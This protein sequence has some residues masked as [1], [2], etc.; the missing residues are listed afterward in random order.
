MRTN[1]APRPPKVRSRGMRL[2]SRLRPGART[3][4]TVVT[5][6]VELRR[7]PPTPAWKDP[8]ERRRRPA[9]AGRGEGEGRA[10]GATRGCRGAGRLHPERPRYVSPAATSRA[11]WSSV[12]L[13]CVAQFMV[14]LDV[15]V[16]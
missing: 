11:R 2:R 6:I 15:S 16:V 9:R 8:D 1:W 4:T 10:A 5:M 12:V 3:R 7:R 13:A 14:I